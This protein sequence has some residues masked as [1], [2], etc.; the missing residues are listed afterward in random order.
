MAG[1][2]DIILGPVADVVKDVIDRQVVDKNAALITKNE[3]DKALALAA[4]SE[5]NKQ[6]D[7]NLAEAANPNLWVSGWRPGIGWTCAAAY[8][9]NYVVGPYFT[10]FKN[11]Y[12]NN[13][14]PFPLL[15]LTSM[16]PV[17]IGLLG[18]GGLRTFDNY[19]KGKATG[20]P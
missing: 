14:A 11:L 7:I 9:S 6:L 8:F 18:L 12:E 3:I 5:N 13:P 19:I 4:I 17:L 2:F 20:G 16:A 1:I 15:D 10:F